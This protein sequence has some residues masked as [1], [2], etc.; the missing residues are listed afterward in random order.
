MSVYNF[1]F[2]FLSSFWETVCCL[3][4]FCLRYVQMVTYFCSF[5]RPQTKCTVIV[6]YLFFVFYDCISLI[7]FRCL[8]CFSFCMFAI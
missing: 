5:S 8:F 6:F 1:P 4:F 3:C 7:H 2:L